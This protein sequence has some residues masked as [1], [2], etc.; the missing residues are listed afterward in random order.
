MT[1]GATSRVLQDQPDEVRA[2]VASSIR[3]ALTPYLKGQDVELPGAIW[4]VESANI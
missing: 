3:A 2:K 4:I 1:I